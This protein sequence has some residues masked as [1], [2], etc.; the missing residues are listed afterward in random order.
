MKSKT[1]RESSDEPAGKLTP[2]KDSLPS[3]EELFP[4][5]ELAKITIALDQ[6]TLQFF[7][8]KASKLG[9]KYQ[10]MIREVLKGYAK[11]YR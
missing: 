3:P 7:K 9:L 1:R 11:R 6:E 8:S 10:K 4:P 5:D 2:I